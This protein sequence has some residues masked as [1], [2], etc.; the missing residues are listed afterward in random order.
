MAGRAV[1]MTSSERRAV[2]TGIGTVNPIGKDLATCWDSLR[3]GKSGVHTIQNF[4]P[5]GLPVR[6]AGEVVNFDAKQFVDKK[7]RKSLR[8]MAR[9]IQLAV[10][11]AQLALNDSQ[12]QIDDL[13]PTRFGVEFGASLIAS[14]LEELG[15]AS[16]VSANGEPGIVDLGKW[17]S[18][19]LSN[20]P[21]LWMLKYLPNM[22]A[23]HISIM[24]NA[25]GPN[26]TI[27]ESD[28]A[29]MLA[30]GEAFRILR[31]NQADY[32]LVG[33]AES[34][35]NPLSMVRQCLFQPLSKRNEEPTK[36]SRPFDRQRDGMVLGEGASVLMLEE[37]N[38]AQKRKAK[39]YGEL[40]GFGAAFDRGLTGRGLARAIRA[41]LSE[42]E[43]D[44]QDID[45]INANGAGTIS[46]DVWEAR[47]LQEVFGDCRPAVPAFAAK[48]YF[49]NLGAG[50]GPTE[51]LTSLLALKH[52]QLP[53][54]LNYQEPDPACPVTVT[55]GE[56]R[57]ISKPYFLKTGF[58]ELG[59]CAA[60]VFR[61]WE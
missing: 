9:S 46:G 35:I 26:N 57:P 16:L 37:L 55:T 8:M 39:I 28:V 51:I 48:S 54:T 15:Q 59:Q 11:A 12:A 20:I 52:G 53:A 45:H 10:A 17:G 1:I 61:R 38:H 4:D 19:G 58:T 56:L 3:Q 23:C 40:V 41:A 42:A 49:G 6:F 27:T 25:Q 5:A 21:P 7:D 14:E 29:G 18:Q 22:L 50:S 44:P 34:R 47:G 30:I 13:D 32:F 31:R 43:I 24:H 36:A 60:A 2:V 33:G